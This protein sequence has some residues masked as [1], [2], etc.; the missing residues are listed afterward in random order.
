MAIVS[1]QKVLNIR[2]HPFIH[3]FTLFF[4]FSAVVHWHPESRSLPQNSKDGTR[5]KASELFLQQSAGS[6][7]K[8]ATYLRLHNSALTYLA[9]H[10]NIFQQFASHVEFLEVYHLRENGVDSMCSLLQILLS[11]NLKSVGM[12]FPKVR[13]INQ[14]NKI[15]HIN[16]SGFLTSKP[17]VVPGKAKE[18]S[19]KVTKMPPNPTPPSTPSPTSNGQPLQLFVVQGQNNIQLS[20]I[21]TS[22]VTNKP[23]VQSKPQEETTNQDAIEAI[24]SK[25]VT[26]ASLSQVISINTPEHL[27]EYESVDFY[28]F[29]DHRDVL[30]IHNSDQTKTSIEGVSFDTNELYNEVFHK[31]SVDISDDS[32]FSI[33]NDLFGASLLEDHQ[34]LTKAVQQQQEKEVLAPAINETPAPETPEAVGGFSFLQHFELSSFWFHDNLLSLFAKSLQQW[35]NLESL[36]LRDNAI[37]FQSKGKILIDALIPLCLKG[38]LRYLR[39]EINP[40]DDHFVS[41]ISE[42]IG[43]YCLACRSGVQ[44]S[45]RVL[46]LSSSKITALGVNHLAKKLLNKCSC[47]SVPAV[48]HRHSRRMR[49]SLPEPLTPSKR[50]RLLRHHSHEHGAMVG[51]DSSSCS[52]ISTTSSSYSSSSQDSDSQDSFSQE[53]TSLHLSRS[54]Q[55]QFEGLE[56]LTICSVIGDEGAFTLSN[57]LTNNSTLTYLALPSCGIHTT[58]LAA[59]FRAISGENICHRQIQR[60]Q[61]QFLSEMFKFLKPLLCFTANKLVFIVQPVSE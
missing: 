30:D 38:K 47:Q 49:K 9:S 44:T 12:C 33:V 15:L 40:V 16:S 48:L 45:L 61:K 14:W 13:D 29:S 34:A 5:A 18:A 22:V 60:F 8:Y 17:K 3:S 1:M 24:I 59:I 21:D 46:Y 56:E 4:L 39:I 37:G 28:D 31:Q 32:T 26:D 35:H 2:I 58:G 23:V 50:R 10:L 54:P 52:S 36:V 43:T 11:K 57:V 53:M 6:F 25:H 27:K 19:S 55:P 20:V 42:G 51:D 41:L 7:G